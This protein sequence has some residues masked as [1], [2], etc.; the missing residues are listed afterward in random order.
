MLLLIIL[1]LLKLYFEKMKYYF[2]IQILFHPRNKYLL[3]SFSFFF[4]SSCMSRTSLGLHRS[5]CEHMTDQIFFSQFTVF[6]TSAWATFFRKNKKCFFLLSWP[7]SEAVNTRNEKYSFSR[8]SMFLLW[9]FI[10]LEVFMNWL[11]IISVV[12]NTRVNN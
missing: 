10:Y 4:F 1:F 7:V 5:A 3:F 11:T 2:T 9:L 12:I 6:F 8:F